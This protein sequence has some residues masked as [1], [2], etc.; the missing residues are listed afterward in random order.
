MATQVTPDLEQIVQ[1]CTLQQRAHTFVDSSGRKEK[2]G[3][4]SAGVRTTHGGESEAM[5]EQQ[6]QA[7]K[8]PFP[9][10]SG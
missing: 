4:S 2:G 10:A 9:L 8:S 3:K 1:R 5:I 7:R 6:Q